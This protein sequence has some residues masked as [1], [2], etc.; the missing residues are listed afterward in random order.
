LRVAIL[1]LYGEILEKVIV[2]GVVSQT[3]GRNIQEVKFSVGKIMFNIEGILSHEIEYE[4]SKEQ[5]AYIFKKFLLANRAYG[6]FVK[7]FAK[8]HKSNPNP[9]VV[10]ADSISALKLDGRS[11]KDIIT[12]YASA[13]NWWRTEKGGTY[14]AA[15]NDKWYDITK[16]RFLKEIYVK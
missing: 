8:Y 11:I 6:E 1:R 3:N 15:L 10:I 9:K 16:R 12:A 4:I 5:L 14:W 7:E 13:F 2:S